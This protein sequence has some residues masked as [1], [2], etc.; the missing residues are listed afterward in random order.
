[1]FNNPIRPARR[2]SDP[3]RATEVLRPHW[4]SLALAFVAVLGETATD[5]LEPWP[6]KVVIDNIVQSKPLPHWLMSVGRVLPHDKFV[7]L[8]IAVVAVIVIALMGAV[9]TYA[10]K[11]LTTSVSQWVAH[12]LR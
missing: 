8:N 2:T 1:M 9:S 7:V 6:I 3:L 10:E 5:V 12:D 4:K 11:S